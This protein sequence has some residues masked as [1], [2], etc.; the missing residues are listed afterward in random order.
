MGKPAIRFPPKA[1]RSE[2]AGRAF[3]A[4]HPGHEAGLATKKIKHPLSGFVNRY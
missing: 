4:S 3:L 1:A 2:R